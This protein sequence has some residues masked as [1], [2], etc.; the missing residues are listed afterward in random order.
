MY[1]VGSCYERHGG[2]G[3]GLD[4]DGDETYQRML[5]TRIYARIYFMGCTS[6]IN[7]PAGRIDIM[8]L[9]FY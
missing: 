4:V 8:F 1:Y 6:A 7:L 3:W 2:A 9:Y 5:L